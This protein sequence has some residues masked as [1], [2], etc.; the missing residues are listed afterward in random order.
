M[1][2]ARRG[3]RPRTRTR[4]RARST[5]RRS[6]LTRPSTSR[7][8]SARSAWRGADI[9][10]IFGL[11]LAAGYWSFRGRS[12]PEVD[13]IFLIGFVLALALV[14]FVVALRVYGNRLARFLPERL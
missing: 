10:V 7:S 8:P 13:L 14:L 11:A 2:T 6:S 1:R 3:I 4:T 9:V 5:R 12:R